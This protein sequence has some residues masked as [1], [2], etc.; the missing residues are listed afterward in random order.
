MTSYRLIDEEAKSRRLET[1]IV[2]Q[3]TAIADELDREWAR[4]L[5]Y[6]ERK[7][8][9]CGCSAP[10]SSGRYLKPIGRQVSDLRPSEYSV[11][12]TLF[13]GLSLFIGCVVLKRTV[14]GFW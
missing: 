12:G 11:R 3:L 9:S 10:H 2:L 8:C 14:G 1:M 13:V 4:K 7:R 5:P 6:Q